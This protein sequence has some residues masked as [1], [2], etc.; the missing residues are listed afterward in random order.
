MV[1]QWN[2]RAGFVDNSLKPCVLVSR[3]MTAKEKWAEDKAL[4][5]G[6]RERLKAIAAQGKETLADIA[7]QEKAVAA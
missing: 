6:L 4:R 1:C 7:Q 2:C 5:E 3:R